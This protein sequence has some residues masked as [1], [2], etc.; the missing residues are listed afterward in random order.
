VTIFAVLLAAEP[1][2]VSNYMHTQE[3][4]LRC[5]DA[6]LTDLIHITFSI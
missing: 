4:G 3:D 5:E 1:G 6:R 2:D